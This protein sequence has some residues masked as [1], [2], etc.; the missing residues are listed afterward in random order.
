[1]EAPNNGEFLFVE[2]EDLVFVGDLSRDKNELVHA[3][4]ISI[5]PAGFDLYGVWPQLD[6]V[7]FGQLLD[8]LFYLLLR[9]AVFPVVLYGLLNIRTELLLQSF[10]SAAIQHEHRHDDAGDENEDSWEVVHTT[11]LPLLMNPATYRAYS[12]WPTPLAKN[13]NPFL[14]RV[15]LYV[16]MREELGFRERMVRSPILLPPRPPLVPENSARRA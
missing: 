13:C 2:G 12:R 15:F 7:F 1:M 14:G 16:E 5:R 4:L 9:L 11:A 8:G 10:R 6:V 3:R